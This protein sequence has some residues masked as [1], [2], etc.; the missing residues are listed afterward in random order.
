MDR[1]IINGFEVAGNAGPLC[2][3][4]MFGVCFIVENWIEIGRKQDS[5]QL[6]NEYDQ[7]VELD[8]KVGGEDDT[9]TE[10]I[11]DLRAPLQFKGSLISCMKECCKRAFQVQPQRLM[12]A[13]YTCVIQTTAEVLG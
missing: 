2:E 11:S 9:E 3:E 8:D 5:E 4:P 10:E 6:E 12:W 1:S 13:M 7:K